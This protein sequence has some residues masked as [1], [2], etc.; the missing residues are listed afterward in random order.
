MQKSVVNAEYQVRDAR[1]SWRKGAFFRK[2]VLP[3][4]FVAPILLIN[5][6]VVL[7]PAISAGY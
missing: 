3:W 4:L 5:V 7:G 2:K 6:M 1:V